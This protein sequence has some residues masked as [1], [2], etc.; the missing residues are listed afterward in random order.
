[1]PFILR[2]Y[3]QPMPSAFTEHGKILHVGNVLGLMGIDSM[4]I[5]LGWA[6]LNQRGKCVRSDE[7]ETDGQQV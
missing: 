3:L 7:D 5:A 2:I 4:Q 1:M 6:R